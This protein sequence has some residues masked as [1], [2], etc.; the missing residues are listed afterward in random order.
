MGLTV[1]ALAVYQ[2]HASLSQDTHATSA[3]LPVLIAPS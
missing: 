3:G 1:A 2:F